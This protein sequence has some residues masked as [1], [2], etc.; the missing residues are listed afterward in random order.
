MFLATEYSGGQNFFKKKY[1]SKFFVA[2]M[3]HVPKIIIKVMHLFT[4]KNRKHRPNLLLTLRATFSKIRTPKNIRDRYQS[5]F[6][7]SLVNVPVGHTEAHSLI[8]C[9]LL[10]I[11]TFLKRNK[12]KV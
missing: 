10:S 2:K 1:L 11:L 4:E 5:Y 9:E 3:K 7:D 8:R 12:G 6:L